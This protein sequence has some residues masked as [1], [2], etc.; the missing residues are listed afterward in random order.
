M[1]Y[2]ILFVALLFNSIFL[3]AQDAHFSQYNTSR[4]FTNPAFTGTDKTLVLS[5]GYRIQWPNINGGYK[6]FCFS[7]DQYVHFLRGGFGIN[8]LNDNEAN[9]TLITSKIDINY[10][11]HFELFNHALVVQPAISIG[12]FKKSIDWSKLTFGDQIDARRG[13]IY[14]SGEVQRPASKYNVDFSAGLLLYSTKFYGGFAAHHLTQPDEGFMGPAKLPMRLTVHAGANLDFN[15]K[16]FIFSPAILLM[17]QAGSQ[18][19]LPGISTK[20]KWAVL[21]LSYRNQDA[22]IINGGFQNRFLKIAY[23]YD[24]TISKLT[25]KATGGSHEIQMAWF[26]NYQKKEC[27]IKTIRLI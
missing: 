5:G 9:G 14:N 18:M 19:I 4:T 3:I 11:P 13:F 2:F 10:A 15:A 26:I 6:T 24:Y 25:N 7:A 12:L 23:S 16:N 8:Y 17:K 21:A 20:Y 1:K 22:F 27:R